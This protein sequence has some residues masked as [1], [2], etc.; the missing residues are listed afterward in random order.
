MCFEKWMQQETKKVLFPSH[1][2]SCNEVSMVFSCYSRKL[3]RGG[4]REREKEGKGEGES[5]NSNCCFWVEVEDFFLWGISLLFS[6]SRKP[7]ENSWEQETS[8]LLKYPC[9]VF[10]VISYTEMFISEVEEKAIKCHLK[11][12]CLQA[13]CTPIVLRNLLSNTPSSFCA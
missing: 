9:L 13:H 10:N 12:D 3:E 7:F 2:S 11:R 4:E 5:E 8:F 1:F 6:D